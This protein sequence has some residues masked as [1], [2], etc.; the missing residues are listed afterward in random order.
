LFLLFVQDIGHAHGGYKPP[1]VS[2]S[3]TP[4]SLAG[5]QVILIGR[6]WVIAEALPTPALASRLFSGPLKPE[7]GFC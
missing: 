6:F 4:L 2:M 3:R 7:S 5:F 1:R